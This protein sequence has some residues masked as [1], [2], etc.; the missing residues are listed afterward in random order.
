MRLEDVLWN[1]KEAVLAHFNFILGY[2]FE[3]TEE[4][5]E[6]PEDSR[7]SVETRTGYLPYTSLIFYHFR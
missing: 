7:I 6:D 2:S 3:G 1:G 4:N 5:Y